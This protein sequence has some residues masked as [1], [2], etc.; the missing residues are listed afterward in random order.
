MNKKPYFI[1]T[2]IPYVNAQPHVGHSLEYIE[3]D[4]VAR[5]KRL[6]GSDVFFLSGADENSL[7]NVQAAEK[8]GK[9][10]QTFVDEHSRYFSAFKDSLNISFDDFIKTTEKRHKDGAQKLWGKFDKK[11]IE[12]KAYKGL[13]CVGCEAFFKEEEL[14]DGKCPDHK[15]EP[16]VIEEENWFFKL[17]NYQKQLKELVE[18]DIIKITPEF[19]KNEWLAFIDRGLEDFSISRSKE[20]AHGW[21]VEVPEDD[22]QIM[23]VWVDALSNYTNALDFSGDETLYK[24]YWVQGEEREVVHV[25]GKGIAKFHVLYWPAMLLS[26]GM[27]LPTEIFVHGYMTIEGEKMSKSLGNVINPAEL[28]ETY[29]KDAVRYYFLGAVSSTKD[30]DF[31]KDRFEEFYTAHLVNGIGNLTSRVLT[32]LEKYSEGVVPT[33]SADC[34]HTDKIYASYIHAFENYAFEGAI[35]SINEL[36]RAIDTKISEERPWEKAKNGEDISEL[37]YQLVEGLRHIALLLIPVIPDTAQKIFAQL[38]YSEEEI[39]SFLFDKEKEWGVLEQ[40]TDVKRDNI[41]FARLTS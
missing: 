24:E 39:K 28:V 26:A 34:F 2:S 9:D 15:K 11:D 31:S 35:K 32:M 7:K 38:G 40:G 30:G 1:S 23:Y 5:Y 8:A 29:G 33:I 22:E 37:L 4:A 27:P 36:V 14:I 6:L 19:R 41:L 20:R 16:E 25:I 12:K 17:S 3:T 10:V 13:Y 21:G 18:K